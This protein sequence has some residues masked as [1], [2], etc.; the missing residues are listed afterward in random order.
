MGYRNYFGTMKKS[1]YDKEKIKGKDSDYRKICIYELY[2]L[3]KNVDFSIKDQFTIIEDFDDGD[4]EFA[5]VGHDAILKVIEQYT[6]S[7]VKYLKSL[8]DDVE[9]LE[10][11]ERAELRLHPR[12]PELYIKQQ[13]LKWSNADRH[14]YNTNLECDEIVSS[15][16][17]QYEIFELL[18]I[19]KSFDSKKYH[20]IWLGK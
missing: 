9:D 18:R 7:H 1:D 4:T 6:K 17:Y 16:E 10:D 19:Y 3:G 12:S 11:Y 5:I 14:I 20:L 8:V 2:E 15:W 13:I